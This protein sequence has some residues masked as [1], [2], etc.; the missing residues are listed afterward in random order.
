MRRAFSFPRF[1]SSTHCSI[2]DKLL[3]NSR[4]TSE[5]VALAWMMPR[6]SISFRLTVQRLMSFYIGIFIIV[7]FKSEI[8]RINT[9]RP[10]KILHFKIPRQPALPQHQAF[11]IYLT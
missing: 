11:M 8:H 5:I 9:T 1:L 2:S 3:S 6:T 10:Y 7:Y 4:L